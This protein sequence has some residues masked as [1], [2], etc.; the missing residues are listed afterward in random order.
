[1]KELT[2]IGRASVLKRLERVP[3]MEEFS[4]YIVN[5]F[6]YTPLDWLRSKSL[7][8]GAVF[9]LSH[10]LQQLYLFR[11][12]FE[13]PKVKNLYYVG[14]STRPGN[15]VPLVMIGAKLLVQKIMSSV[16]PP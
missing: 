16:P 5:E 10:N 7:A 15:G 12:S 13:S 1:M 4:S 6:V 14:A 11:P 3:G 2:N 8:R 9:G